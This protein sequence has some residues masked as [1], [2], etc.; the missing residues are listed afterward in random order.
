M[1]C[2]LAV[3]KAGSS[4]QLIMY[5]LEALIL[6]FAGKKSSYFGKK[7][8]VIAGKYLL[9]SLLLSSFNLQEKAKIWQV[10]EKQRWGLFL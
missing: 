4:I 8:I 9:F 10:N 3:V 2:Q 5:L 1:K 6:F 7:S